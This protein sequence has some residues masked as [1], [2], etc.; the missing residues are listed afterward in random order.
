LVK[1]CDLKV[2]HIVV[3]NAVVV[4]NFEGIPVEAFL[5]VGQYLAFRVDGG[6]N[7]DEAL[8]FFNSCARFYLDMVE[9]VVLS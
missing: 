4:N 3:L 9:L 5:S 1:V 6:F 2:N 8:E 7:S